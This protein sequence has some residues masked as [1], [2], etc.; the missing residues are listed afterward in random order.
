VRP[1]RPQLHYALGLIAALAMALTNL[2]GLWLA[3]FWWQARIA[4]PTGVAVRYP[5][6]LSGIHNVRDRSLE[7]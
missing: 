4:V 5:P 7:R 6:L 3:T 1:F 2:T